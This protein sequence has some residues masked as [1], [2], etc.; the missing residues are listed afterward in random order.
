MG[1]FTIGNLITLGMVV[2]ILILYRQVDKDNRSL[3]KVRKYVDKCKEDLKAY[4]REQ[5]EEVKNYGIELK[6]EKDSANELMRELQALT[7]EELAEKAKTL[8]RIDERISSYDASLEELVKMTGR[9]QENLN[10][11]RDESAFVENAGRRVGEARQKLDDMEKG[12]GALENR[13]ERENAEALEKAMEAAVFALKS[14]VADMETRVET[15]E[16]KVEDHREAVDKVERTRAANLARDTEIIN[17]ALKEAVERAGT[18]ADKMEETVLIRLRDQAQERIGQVKA[19]WEEKLKSTQE[20]VK[21]RLMEIS[22]QIKSCREEWKT[23]HAEIEGRQRQYRDEWKKDAQELSSLAKQQ[24]EEWAALVRDVE[25]N[26]L[27]DADLRLEE[28]KQVQDEEQRR[29]AGLADDAAQ[30]DQELRRSMQDAVGRV[31]GDFA[32]FEEESRRARKNVGE[33]FNSQARVLQTQ[34]DEL[35]QR[36]NNLRAEAYEN[37]SEKLRAF[38]ETFFADL[39]KRSTEIDRQIGEWHEG[40]D[41]RLAAIAEEGVRERGQVESRLVGE[42]RA[43]LSSQGERLVSELERLK[44]EAVGFERSIREEMRSADESRQSFR[45]QIDRDLEETKSAAESEVK[46]KVG[47]YSLDMSEILRRSQRELEERLREIGAGME[48]RGAALEAASEMSRRGIEE[49][50]SQYNSQMRDLDAS[51][52]EVRR[53]TRDMA[54]ENDERIA[55]ARGALDDIRRELADQTKLFNRTDE[56]KRELDRSIEDINGDFD[57]LEQRRNEIAQMENQFVRIKRLED[58]VNAKMSRFLNEQRRIDDMEVKFNRLLQTSEAVEEKLVQVSSSD[59]TL[60]AAQVQIRRLEDALKETE[61]K[62]QRVERKGQVLEETNDGIDRN[63]KALRESEEAVKRLDAD[64]SIFS[65]EMESIRSSIETLAAENEKAKDTAGKL[66]VL[67]DS[68]SYI[69]KRIAEMQVAREWLARTETELQALDKDAQNMLRLTRS[70]IDR[71]SGKAQGSDKG[72]PPL[73]DRDNI[74]KLRRKG[75]TVDEIAKTLSISKGEV[76]LV[77]ELS[78]KN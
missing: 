7:R 28:Y 47:Q 73:R 34:V 2:L 54:A 18:R 78:P 66:A 6:V 30:L 35:E 50:Q 63:F 77:L 23:E 32:L 11:I 51:M 13:F 5:E 76:E 9:V 20:T 40:F 55:S 67:D 69:E 64:I 42:L 48:A 58:D 68:L 3:D 53:R 12:L 29:L 45:E 24:R 70:L 71:E 61:E 27:A 39:N 56:L 62:Y 17:K 46:T 57:R 14:S 10:R 75:W 59:D 74:I 38:E 1:F 52:E 72:A 65:R 4:V 26:I 25:R 44:A 15:C 41:A 60:Q 31:K 8:A 22:D 37:V 36:L 21:G 19:V 33:E 43:G 49:W 16:R